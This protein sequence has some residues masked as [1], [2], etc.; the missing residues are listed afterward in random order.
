MEEA[1]KRRRQEEVDRLRRDRKLKEDEKRREI[2]RLQE[3]ERKNEL[4]RKIEL[5]RKMEEDR[6]ENELAEKA[7][8]VGNSFVASN[9]PHH[10]KTLFLSMRKQRR[11]SAVQ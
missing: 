8:Q 3:L 9:V 4:E 5:E 10:E 7:L 11:R 1:E 6:K 2:E